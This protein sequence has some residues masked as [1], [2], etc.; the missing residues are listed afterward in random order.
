MVALPGF[1]LNDTLYESSASLVYRGM[2]QADDLPVVL[3]VLRQDYPI[4][5]EINRYRQ[6]YEILQSLSVPGV[7][8]A[9]D[10]VPYQHTY[11]IIFED[12]GGESLSHWM[13]RQ[14]D[15]YRPMT[16]ADF[17]LQAITLADTLDQLHQQQV[18]HKDINPGNIVL[19]PATGQLK[20]IDFGIATQLSRTEPIP[21]SPGG[22]EGTL[23]YLSPE[24]TGRMNRAIDYRTDFY[25]LGSGNI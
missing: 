25:S 22:L 23:A 9:Y 20:L 2:R 13:G 18:I 12:F 19:N 15:L 4:P 21:A 8:R 24:Q 17:L 16:V 7:I 14:P 10:Q 3:K 11:I 6:E 1:T 5:E